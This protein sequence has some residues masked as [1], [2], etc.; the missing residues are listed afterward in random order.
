[1][2]VGSLSPLSFTAASAADAKSRLS[3]GLRISGKTPEENQALAAKEA[4]EKAAAESEAKTELQAS[5]TDQLARG[6]P[7]HGV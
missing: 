1:M 7:G 6:P 2:A 4:S 5:F 3:A